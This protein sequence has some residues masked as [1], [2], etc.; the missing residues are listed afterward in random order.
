MFSWLWPVDSS[1]RRKTT[2]FRK[3]SA[4]GLYTRWDSYSDRGRKIALIR[5]LALRATRI[6]SPCHLDAE[7]SILRYIF[8]RNGYPP[9]VTERVIDS[10]INPKPP[11]DTVK[12]KPVYMRLPWL[13]ETSS[14]FARRIR[15]ATLNAVPYCNT[16]VSFTSR[17]MLNTCHKDV[18]STENLSNVVYFF[19]CDCGRGYVGRTSLRLSERAKQHVPKSL[20]DSVLPS[21]VPPEGVASK[22]PGLGARGGDGDLAEKACQPI[23][24]RTRARSLATAKQTG[25]EHTP[26]S[27]DTSLPESESTPGKALTAP[28]VTKSDSG[29]TRHLKLSTPCLKAV[30]PNIFNHFQVLGKARNAAHLGYLEA[31]YIHTKKPELCSQKEFVK[32]LSLL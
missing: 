24:S 15:Q 25:P 32:S 14:L 23:S 20:I 17:T 10:V 21:D 5:T 29:I 8:L 28:E 11:V 13:G 3:K 6:C 2:V 1:G 16:I 7:L 12:L 30:A 4:T 22:N 31:V 26:S 9:P 18:L 27:K 19:T